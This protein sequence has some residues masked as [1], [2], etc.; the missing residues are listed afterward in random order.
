MTSAT[1]VP[2]RLGI[3]TDKMQAFALAVV[4]EAGI[5]AA[6]AGW[7]YYSA[8]HQAAAEP[9]PI[10]LTTA[11]PEAAKPEAPKP[12]PPKPLPK[13]ATPSKQPAPSPMP[14][15]T[16]VPQSHEATPFAEPAPAQPSPPPATAGKADANLEYAGKV[17]AAVQAAVIYPPAAISLKFSGRTRVSFFLR[18][19]SPSQAKVIISSGMGLIDR[20]ALQSVLNAAYPA[21]PEALRGKDES[22]EI[23]VEFT[24]H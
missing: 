1:T 12:P 16:P 10:E 13:P 15:P 6:A 9:A 18:N 23:W 14:M 11:V 3:S 22:Y 21:P 17:R 7:V 5:L 24:H 19:S 20:A 2:V 8:A 4:I